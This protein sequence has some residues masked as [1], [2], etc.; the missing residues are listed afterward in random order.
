MKGS[1]QGYSLRKLF[2]TA[3]LPER[4]QRTLGV[5]FDE[6]MI[7]EHEMT[8]HIALLPES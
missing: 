1:C 2:G 7:F 8:E 5:I 6:R 3:L 4:N